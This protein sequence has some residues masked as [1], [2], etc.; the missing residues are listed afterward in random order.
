[1]VNYKEL[2]FIFYTIDNLY[3]EKLNLVGIY[4]EKTDFVI[5]TI[6]ALI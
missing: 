3:S 4:Y 2:T 6:L 5:F 1:M